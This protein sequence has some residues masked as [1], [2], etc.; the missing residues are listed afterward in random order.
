MFRKWQESL[1][2][3]QNKQKAYHNAK[4][5]CCDFIVEDQVL[6]LSPVKHSKLQIVWEDP[7]VVNQKVI[8]MKNLELGLSQKFI[9]Q[10]V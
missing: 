8:A 1:E 2:E 9:T 5:R 4:G 3:A 7:F 10:I 6:V